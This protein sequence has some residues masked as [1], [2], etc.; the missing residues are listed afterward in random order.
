M[1]V[2]PGAILFFLFS[3]L[4]NAGQA[5]ETNRVFEF[6]LTGRS[7]YADFTVTILKTEWVLISEKDGRLYDPL[8][9]KNSD[10]SVKASARVPLT[11]GLYQ[12]EI[13]HRTE[14]ITH[15]VTITNGSP[16]QLTLDVATF[17]SA[18]RK[19]EKRLD[20]LSISGVERKP[21]H[22]R[23]VL[24]ADD[25]RLMPG[26]G[27]DVVRSVAN[28]PGVVKTST[29][30]SGMFIR[31]GEIE[32]TLF[33]YDAIRIGNPFHHVGFYSTF[34]PA[35][36]ESLNFYPGL[37]PLKFASE[38]SV[39]EILSKTRYNKEKLK[40]DIDV[41]IAAAGFYLSIP[42]S[43]AVQISV[44]ARRTYYEFYF[45]ILSQIE[46]LKTVGGGVLTS[47]S[48]TQIPFFYD[49][50]VKADWNI[51]SRNTLSAVFIASQDQMIFDT[52]AF[53]VSNT[54]GQSNKGGKLAFQDDWNMEG[55]VYTYEDKR[56]QNKLTLAHFFDSNGFSA[57]EN[58]L[59]LP[60]IQSS[61]EN[62]SVVDQ[63]YAKLADFFAVDFGGEYSFQGFPFQTNS[64]VIDQRQGFIEN[65]LYLNNGTYYLL[66]R[67]QRHFAGF[68]AGTEWF[69]GNF[70]FEAG[71]RANW[72][73]ASSRLDVDPRG[74]ITFEGKKDFSIYAKAGKYSQLPPLVQTIQGYGTPALR[75]PYTLQGLLGGQWKLSV[76]DFKTEIYYEHFYDLIDANTKGGS[77][78]TNSLEGQSYGAELTVKKNISREGLVAWFGYSYNKS[79]RTYYRPSSDSYSWGNFRREVNHSLTLTMAQVLI[80]N[81]LI[82][83]LRTGFS[84]GRP[85]TPQYVAKDPTT[86]SLYFQEQEE[87]NTSFTPPRFTLDLKIEASF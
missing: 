4:G 69:L 15:T 23:S 71:A 85:Y 86:G 1:R 32:D 9:E 84:T 16:A 44:S 83:G 78:F 36:I 5:A 18:K 40:L 64:Y 70:V 56:F 53:K 51:D 77:G 33:T 55:I 12:C 2:L 43:P 48:P 65:L 8:D 31:G 72:N 37:A 61:T 52:T 42:L 41:N 22:G 6:Q 66:G 80:P 30:S 60:S 10:R 49:L 73:S 46:T 13:I 3:G 29:F 11:N 87:K 45:G 39:I 79:D 34:A 20:A 25:A 75:S 27:G 28:V 7:D 74:G 81:H 50:S 58:A 47:F 54:S 38:G 17:K 82:I 67:P 63:G 68:H 57:F 19:E 35:S 26:S 59:G 62:F 76:F 21:E 14:K 24:T